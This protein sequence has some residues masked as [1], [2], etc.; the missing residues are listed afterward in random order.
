ML[1]GRTLRHQPSWVANGPGLGSPAPPWCLTL[2]WFATPP[3]GLPKRSGG[4]HPRVNPGVVSSTALTSSR[5]A[6]PRADCGAALV[7]PWVRVRAAFGGGQLCVCPPDDHNGRP[8]L[9]PC[10]SLSA[11]LSICLPVCLLVCLPACLSVCPGGVR[12]V[13]RRFELHG[14]IRLRHALVLRHVPTVRVGSKPLAHACGVGRHRTPR[15]SQSCAR[16]QRE[17]G[18]RQRETGTRQRSRLRVGC[19]CWVACARCLVLSMLSRQMQHSTSW[20]CCGMGLGFAGGLASAI[21]NKPGTVLS[22]GLGCC[23]RGAIRAGD[24]DHRD[25]PVTGRSTFAAGDGAMLGNA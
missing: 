17:T 3:S 25:K 13:A 23:R 10:V 9:R 5:S 16:R 8:R 20:F 21:E 7:G 19:W 24:G 1:N 2:G 4:G 12:C 14:G 6:H 18:T 15:A 11:C 22:M